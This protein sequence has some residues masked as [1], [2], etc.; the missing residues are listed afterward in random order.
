MDRQFPRALESATLPPVRRPDRSR[1]RSRPAAAAGELVD[2]ILKK[3][4]AMQGVREHRLVTAWVE[5]VGDRVAARA[6]PD[7]LRDGVLS[8]RVAN[9]AWMHELS[10]LREAVTRR[11]NELVG[12]PRLVR[13]VRFHLGANRRTE[14]HQ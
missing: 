6:W 4:G 8:V 7:G 13:E 2:G 12:P 1:K 3:Y 14:S 9:S 10:F 5:I 11:A